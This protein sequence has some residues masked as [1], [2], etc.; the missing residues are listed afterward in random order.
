MCPW[1]HKTLSDWH[2]Q[3]QTGI[4]CERYNTI[5]SNVEGPSAFCLY[6]KLTE[7]CNVLKLLQKNKQ[8]MD[9]AKTFVAYNTFTFRSNGRVNIRISSSLPTFNVLALD[10]I[11]VIKKQQ[12]S[13]SRAASLVE[14]FPAV[15]KVS[16]MRKK[17]TLNFAL[18]VLYLYPVKWR[19]FPLVF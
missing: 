14:K 5:H 6:T 9:A 11:Y 12:R 13:Q 10:C 7:L 3:R 17:K 8:T 4:K 1:W 19:A 18:L 15:H 16:G 2:E